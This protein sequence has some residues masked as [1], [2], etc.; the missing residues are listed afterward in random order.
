VITFESKVHLGQ[1][2][3]SESLNIGD[4]GFGNINKG[5]GEGR[6]QVGECR[7]WALTKGE[8]NKSTK[9]TNGSFANQRACLGVGQTDI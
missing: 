4:D 2:P 7:E 6:E 1:T 5:K 3:I 8:I 9:S